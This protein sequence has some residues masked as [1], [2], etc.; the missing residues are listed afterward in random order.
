MTDDT[1][2]RYHDRSHEVETGGD[3][4]V[5]I[6]SPGVTFSTYLGSSVRL[7]LDRVI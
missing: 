6:V 3:H 7:G 4:P 1:T 5:S 2:L